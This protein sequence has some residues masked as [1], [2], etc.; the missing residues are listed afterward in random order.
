VHALLLQPVH[1]FRHELS[2]DTYV[3]SEKTMF[4]TALRSSAIYC[5]VDD[6]NDDDD[7]DNKSNIVRVDGCK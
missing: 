1:S 5:D 6:D 4:I 3:L 2:S 7:D